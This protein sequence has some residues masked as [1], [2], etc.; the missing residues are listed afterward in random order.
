MQALLLQVYDP[1]QNFMSN[2]VLKVAIVAVIW[3]VMTRRID[4]K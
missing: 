4:K 3:I 2:M 1:F